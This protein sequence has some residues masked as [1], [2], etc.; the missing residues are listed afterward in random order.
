MPQCQQIVRTD[1]SRTNPCPRPAKY[2]VAIRRVP[3][4]RYRCGPCLTMERL[5]GIV[6]AVGLIPSTPDSPQTDSP[7]PSPA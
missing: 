6:E 7:H 3:G 5:D 1:K 2:Q 4:W